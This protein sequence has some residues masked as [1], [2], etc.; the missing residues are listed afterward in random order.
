[1]Q[2]DG[3]IVVA[4]YCDSGT[5]DRICVARFLSNGSALDGTFGGTGYV[6]TAALANV[7]NRAYS[8]AILPMEKSSLVESVAPRDVRFAIYRRLSGHELR[9]GRRG[10]QW[11]NGSGRIRWGYR[12][13]DVDGGVFHAGWNNPVAG[14][15][16]RLVEAVVIQWKIRSSRCTCPRP[17][18]Y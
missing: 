4:G 18:F 10:G 15:D 8:A 6:T 11:R 9:H 17:T 13:L 12:A 14:I 7:N 1:M 5:Y 3:K 16:F 2:T